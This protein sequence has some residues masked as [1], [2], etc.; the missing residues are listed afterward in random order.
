MC[1]DRRVNAHPVQLSLTTFIK[2]YKVVAEQN[3]GGWS[4]LHSSC[5]GHSRCWRHSSSI[6]IRKYGTPSKPRLPLANMCTVWYL[7]CTKNMPCKNAK[8]YIRRFRPPEQ[9]YSQGCEEIV[10]CNVAIWDGL[11]TN[12]YQE[13][14]VHRIMTGSLC[15]NPR[16]TS[17]WRAKEILFSFVVRT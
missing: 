1:R 13:F 11:Y 17:M 3:T 16:S 14:N 8:W 2:H 5:H 4:L 15:R 10:S 9:D 6:E 12:L 7:L